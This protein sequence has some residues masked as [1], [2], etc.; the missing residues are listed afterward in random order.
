MDGSLE[1]EPQDM[2]EFHTL[3][4]R[5]LCASR[6]AICNAM[7]FCFEHSPASTQISQLLKELMLDGKCSVETRIARLYLLSDVLFNSQQ[8]GVKNAF[9]YRDAIE[10][11]SHEVFYSLG[12]HRGMSRMSKHK[13]QTAV[14]TI[15]S[16]WTNWSV[17]DHS[18]LDELETRFKGHEIIKIVPIKIE[19]VEE[20][21]DVIKEEPKDEEEETPVAVASGDWTEVNEEEE[22]ARKKVEQALLGDQALTG[23]DH[24]T[25]AADSHFDDEDID[26]EA[27]EDGDLDQ[28]GLRRLK[29]IHEVSDDDSTEIRHQYEAAR[30][31]LHVDGVART[32]CVEHLDHTTG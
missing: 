11:M 31:E 21:R 1:L 10:K 32:E 29:E 19:Q 12:Q 4:K 14:R 24:L 17:F 2:E 3:T 7:A 20:Q 27:L 30:K 23:R 13:M 26:G 25:R 5:K 22:V 9:R 16:A 28:E 18:F 8:P 6:Q 15:L